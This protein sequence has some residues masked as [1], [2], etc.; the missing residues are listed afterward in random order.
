MNEIKRQQLTWNKGMTNVPS[1]LVCDDNTCEVELNMIY[2]QGEHRPIQNEQVLFGSAEMKPLLFV[3]KYNGYK[4]YI[5]LNGS[6]II[7]YDKDG[8][9]GGDITNEPQ[10]WVKVCRWKE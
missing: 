2:R 10:I 4:H 8:K 5:A 6:R 7:W 9:A 3:H 1:D